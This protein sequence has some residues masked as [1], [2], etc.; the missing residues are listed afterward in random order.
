VTDQPAIVFERVSFDYGADAP[1]LR[2][3]SLAIPAGQFAALTGANGAGKTTLARHLIGL[4][5]ATEG[6]VRVMG[7]D[8][9]GHTT[10]ELARWVGFA[11]QNPEV[12]IFNPTVR[13]ELA[14]GPRNLGLE[15]A[16][17]EEAIARALDDFDLGAWVEYP[18]AA[19]SFSLRRMVAL[20]A[21]AAMRTPILVLD[22]PTVGLDAHGTA[23]L[24]K[25]LKMRQAAGATVLLIT[26][27][28]ELAAQLAERILV[29][30]D[31][32]LTADGPPVE[33]FR[34]GRV[35]AEAGLTPHFAVTLAERLGRP[36]LGQY[37]NPAALAQ[38]LI[39]ILR[40]AE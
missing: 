20:A 39:P 12:Q 8:A 40:G 38:A 9:A 35:L 1:V 7:D 34:G 21:I 13:E 28:M 2:E 4:L 30:H 36:E 14:F 5:R 3:I 10:G 27:D 26:H 24:V 23:H 31:G 15:G 11:F 37:A 6:T 18:P 33:V 16:P 22:E 25:W 19:L 17:L 29:L 32:Q